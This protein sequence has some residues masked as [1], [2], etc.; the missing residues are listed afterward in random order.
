MA[1]RIMGD[2]LGLHPIG[3]II[4]L[5]IGAKLGGMAGVVLALPLLAVAT[6]VIDHFVEFNKLS[7]KRY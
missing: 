3:V 5:I 1:P 2:A 7:V 4:G 6:A